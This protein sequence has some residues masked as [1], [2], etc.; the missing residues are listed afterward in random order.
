VRSWLVAWAENDPVEPHVH[1]GPLAVDAHMQ[2][3][4]LGS[5]IMEEHC[6]RL[7][8]ARQAGYLETD[9]PGNVVFYGKF[10]YEPVAEATVIGVPNW[11]MRRSPA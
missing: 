6:Q 4:G 1:L 3:R 10:G 7:D 2:G 11:F 9:K 5:L 8:R